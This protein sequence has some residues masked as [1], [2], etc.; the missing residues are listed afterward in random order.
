MA[1]RPVRLFQSP[2]LRFRS[3]IRVQSIAFSPGVMWA[4]GCAPPT[5]AGHPVSSQVRCVRSSW[6]RRRTRRQSAGGDD[7][8]RPPNSIYPRNQAFD[9]A[10]TQ[11]IP[12]CMVGRWTGQSPPAPADTDARQEGGGLGEEPRERPLM[13]GQIRHRDMHPWSYHV[14]RGRGAEIA[15]ISGP[16]K[17]GR[18][19]RSEGGRRRLRLDCRP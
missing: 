13:P 6:C 4:L 15:T 3:V 18:P 7:L 9:Q 8:H 11:H 12:D 10:V 19:A 16:P 17:G 5:S 14:E 2:Y 1:G